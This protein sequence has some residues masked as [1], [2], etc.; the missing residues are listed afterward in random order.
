MK[1]L[2]VF[3][4]REGSKAP[5]VKGWHDKAAPL[6]EWLQE[7]PGH[8]RWGAPCGPRNG[9]WVL[10]IDPRHG[11]L[12]SLSTLQDRYGELLETYTVRTPS[13]GYHFY[14]LWGPLCELL[15]NTA[16]KL[17]PGLDIRAEGGMVLV[18]PTDGYE[19]MT[20]CEPVAAPAWLL[21]LLLPSASSASPAKSDEQP[22]RDPKAHASRAIASAIEEIQAAPEGTRDATMN[23]NAYGLGRIIGICGLNR[24]SVIDLLVTTAVEAGYNAHKALDCCTRGVDAGMKN[25]RE[26]AASP[27]PAAVQAGG[28]LPAQAVDQLRPCPPKPSGQRPAD[29]TSQAGLR[30]DAQNNE[31]RAWQRD[32]RT[33]LDARLVTIRYDQS[34]VLYV[35]R[36]L[37]R[38]EVLGTAHRQAGVIIQVA[39]EGGLLLGAAKAS[40]MAEEYLRCNED[41]VVQTVPSLWDNGEGLYLWEAPAVEAGPTPTWDGILERMSD[42]V[43]FLAHVWSAFEPRFKGRQVLWLQGDG[44]DGKSILFSAIFEGSG[45]PMA[46]VNDDDLQR[47]SQFLF[48]TVWDKPAVLIGDSKSVNLMMMGAVHRL[49]GRDYIGV[50]YKHGARFNAKFQGVVWVASNQR[51][52]IEHSRSNLSRLSF[53][54]IRPGEWVDGLAG[55]LR[56]ELPGLLARAREAYVVACPRHF[57]IQL[58]DASREL[59]GESTSADH[60][61]HAAALFNAGLRIEGD[62]FIAR[63]DIVVRMNG[64]LDDGKLASFYRWLDQQPGVRAEKAHGVRGFR[65]LKS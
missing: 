34:R 43:A 28:H 47:A 55:K 19:I 51:P 27:S 9:W 17:G 2:N 64:K 63:K 25:P 32:L 33:I 65:G 12:E 54:T 1:E 39:G 36:G 29:P 16:G 41:R 38:V 59:L 18:P 62:D 42:P 50:E 60:E 48:S 22:V 37:R 35:R 4:V 49:T 15:T 20:T 21:A 14:F 57:D 44:N 3:P 26:V 11:G 10:D 58:N 56:A 40:E 31:Y 46:A 30:W 23:R 52:Q 45:V 24:D 5:A 53:L 7:F 6:A 61:K 13:G 8:L